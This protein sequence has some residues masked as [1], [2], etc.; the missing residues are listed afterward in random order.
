MVAKQIRGVVW[1]QKSQKLSKFA[2]FTAFL[3]LFSPFGENETFCVK[4]GL[5]ADHFISLVSMLTKSAI[6]DLFWK[7]WTF[8]SSPEQLI[9]IIWF[10]V[11]KQARRRDQLRGRSQLLQE[12]RPQRS[13]SQSPKGLPQKEEFLFERKL[14]QIFL[15]GNWHLHGHGAVHYCSKTSW[16][17]CRNLWVRGEHLNQFELIFFWFLDAFLY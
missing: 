2:I 12:E 13:C 8:I 3:P 5:N 7:H 6:A 17:N 16:D 1:T 9:T 11:W 14:M 4:C 10:S 15:A